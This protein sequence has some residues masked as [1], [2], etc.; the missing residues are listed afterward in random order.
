MAHGLF[1]LVKAELRAIGRRR[2]DRRQTHTD[3]TIVEVYFWAV[4]NDRPVSWA[5]FATNWAG[6]TRR[7]TLPSQPAMSRRLRTQSVKRLIAR[8]ESRVR[9]RLQQHCIVYMIDGKALQI[10]AHSRDPDAT[11]GRISGGKGT[12]YK[13]HLLM[14]SDGTLVAWEVAPLNVDERVIARKLLKKAKCAGYILGDANYDTST[15]HD[16]ALE[17]GGQLIAPRNAS[18]RGTGLGIHYQSKGRLRSIEML[19][20][21]ESMFG[22]ELYKMRGAIERKFGHLASTPGLLTHL[23]AWVRTLRRVTMWV[24][25]K[26]ILADL[27]A[28]QR[29]QIAQSVA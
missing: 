24:Q 25:A 19:E 20:N 10:S 13:L 28:V 16:V 14:A 7:A 2:T 9:R 11:W 18:H 6:V 17:S 15:L 3:A 1:G 21:S 12:G 4:D 23:P 22:H 26:L 27:R 5:C 29:R 8:I